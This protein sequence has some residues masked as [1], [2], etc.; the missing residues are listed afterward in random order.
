MVEL[1]KVTLHPGS[2]IG[3]AKFLEVINKHQ[4]FGEIN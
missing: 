3:L 2:D 4:P 1:K